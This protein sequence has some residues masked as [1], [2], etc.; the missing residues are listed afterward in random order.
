MTEGRLGVKGKLGGRIP[1]I[2]HAFDEALELERPE[3][4]EH[5]DGIERDECRDVVDLERRGDER[6]HHDLLC[7]VQIGDTGRI[8]TRIA[9]GAVDSRDGHLNRFLVNN[10]AGPV[11]DEV[12]GPARLG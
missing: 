11:G 10:A 5:A 2:H 3:E 6:M 9:Q 1:S 8:G 4:L 7:G 12:V